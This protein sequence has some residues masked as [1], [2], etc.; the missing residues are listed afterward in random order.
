MLGKGT[1]SWTKAA[2]DR[3]REL[4]AAGTH[5][6]DVAAE[7]NTTRASIDGLTARHGIKREKPVRRAY[8]WHPERI[9]QLRK[10]KAEGKT[11]VEIGSVMGLH[12]K[13]VEKA[14]RRFK[15]GSLRSTG[16]NPSRQWSEAEVKQMLTLWNSG[17]KPLE[18]GKRMGRTRMQIEGKATRLGLARVNVPKVVRPLSPKPEGKKVVRLRPVAGPKEDLSVIPLTA[19]PW[20]TRERGECNFPYGQRGNIHSCCAPV[21][22]ETTY[23]ESHFALCHDMTKYNKR[24]A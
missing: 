8:T 19:R 21:W 20:L 17:V 4:W 23:C 2:I 11:D 1:K 15:I 3:L 7:L 24:A 9:E 12:E 5:V 16:Q 22:N 14:R 13:S 10:L 6:D 18:I